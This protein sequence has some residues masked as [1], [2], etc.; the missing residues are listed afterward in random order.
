MA[1]RTS[2]FLK[3]NGFGIAFFSLTITML[4]VDIFEGFWDH[5]SGYYFLQSLLISK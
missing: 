3:K 2:D 4:F 5:D 1:S